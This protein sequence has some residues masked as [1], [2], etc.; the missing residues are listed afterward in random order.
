MGRR[1][2]EMDGC[3]LCLRVRF[4]LLPPLLSTSCLLLNDCCR[5]RTMS[6]SVGGFDGGAGVDAGSAGTN[7]AGAAGVDAG[8]AG[9]DA[10][11]ACGL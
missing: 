6:P 4:L 5:L 2:A 11:A 10:G 9:V 1:D 7:D 3:F 8:A